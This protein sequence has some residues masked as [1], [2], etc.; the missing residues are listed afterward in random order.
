MYARFPRGRYAE[1]AAWKA[2][3]TSYRKGDMSE[4]VRAFRVGGRELSALGL[5]AGMAVLVGPR[6][7]RDGRCARRRR[8]LS[9]DDRRLSQHV[10]RP[11]GGG[12]APEAGALARRRAASCLRQPRRR[13]AAKTTYF[14]PTEDTIRMLLALRIVRAG[15]EGAGVRA[16]EVGRFAGHHRDDRVGEQADGGIRVG[17]RAVRARARLDYA[18]EAGVSAVHGERR[19]PAAA[20]DPDDDLSAGVLGSHQEER[21]AARISIRISSPR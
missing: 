9:A 13:S 14:P 20:R 10:L 5:P 17:H 12:H 6:A 3:W 1:R 2:G 21:G 15:G 8:A 16:R 18:D 4:A 11:A 7:R 19:R